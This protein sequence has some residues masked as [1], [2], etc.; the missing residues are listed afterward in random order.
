MNSTTPPRLRVHLPNSK[1]I[2]VTVET[3]PFTIGRR[4]ECNL[5]IPQNDVS[6]LQAEIHREDGRYVLV[7]KARTF[8][9]KVNGGAS[10]RHILANRD[11]ITM[12]RQGEIEML[13]LLKDSMSE[14]VQ[15]VNSRP[16]DGPTH[17]DYRNLTLL[18]ELGRRLNS[19]RSLREVL[20]LT[21][22]AVLDATGTERGFLMMRDEEGVLQIVD[23]A[24]GY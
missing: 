18:L 11:V 1:D 20:E 3:S 4:P 14:I 6:R 9:T 10:R 13:F 19:M 5:V 7:D 23:R 2:V 22:D 16:L 8:P 17:E 15:N 21:L 24:R 12:G